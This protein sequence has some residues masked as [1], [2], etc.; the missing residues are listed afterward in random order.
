MGTRQDANIIC[1]LIWYVCAPEVAPFQN[2]PQG[3]EKVH[4]E[5]RIDIESIIQEVCK[6]VMILVNSLS[7]KFIEFFKGI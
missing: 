4:Y 6:I 7:Q 2:A 5:C 3:V 1:R